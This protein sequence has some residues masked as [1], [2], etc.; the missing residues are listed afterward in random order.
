M[1]PVDS[2]PVVDNFPVVDSFNAI[3]S[4]LR[5]MHNEMSGDRGNGSLG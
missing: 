5:D 1:N 2:F 4:N 3:K